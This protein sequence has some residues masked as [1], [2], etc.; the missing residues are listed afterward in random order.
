MNTDGEIAFKIEAV[1][2]QDLN[3]RNDASTKSD[4]VG[5]IKAGMVVDIRAVKNNGAEVW[6]RIDQYD[7]AGWINM[8]K[9]NVQY[10]FEG[11]VNTDEQPIYVDASTGSTVKGTLPLNYK[12]E[13]TKVTTDGTNVY[14]WVEENIF[15]WIPMSKISPN[16][17]DVL[18]VF[19]SGESVGDDSAYLVQG[20]TFASME[21]YDSIGGTKVLF[22]V[23]SGVITYIEEVRFQNGRIWAMVSGS[24]A[25]Y[26][27]YMHAWLDLTK[28]NYSLVGQVATELNVRSS[29]DTSTTA[30]DNPNNIVEV[31]EAGVSINICQLSFDAYGNLWAR[32]SNNSSL[33]PQVNGAYIMIMKAD[34]TVL[35]DTSIY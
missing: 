15:G 4:R 30:Q 3:V 6:G 10:L 35:V 28:I 17:I 18:K 16:M 5:T 2:L 1:I 12:L 29:M 32:L 25:V 23:T 8:D 11:Y 31:L 24:D 21:A 22:K 14:G 34:K 27:E 7:T 33:D 19:K 13:I 26:G 9:L 20:T